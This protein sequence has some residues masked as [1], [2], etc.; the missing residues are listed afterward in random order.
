MKILSSIVLGLALTSSSFSGEKKQST[1][2]HLQNVSVTIRAEGPYSAG[3]GSG[4]IFTR[5]DLKGN[6]VNNVVVVCPQNSSKLYR[7]S[8]VFSTLYRAGLHLKCALKLIPSKF[9]EKFKLQSMV[10]AEHSW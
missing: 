7:V 10:L 5:T 2:D 6:L 9:H 1:A 3:E 4:V 8:L